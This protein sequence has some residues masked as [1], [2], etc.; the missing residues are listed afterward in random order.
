MKFTLFI[1]L[2]LLAST[3]ARAGTVIDRIIATGRLKCGAIAEPLDWN[4]NDLHASLAPLDAEMCRAVATAVLGAPDRFDLQS[5]NSEADGL[6]GLLQGK[7][8]IV[9]GVT[10]N[11]TRAARDGVRFSLP[12]FQD[13]QG[14]MVHRAAGIRTLADM[15]GHKLCYIDGTDNAAVVLSVLGALHVRPVPFPFQEEGEMDAA[16]MDLHCQVTSALMSKLAEARATFHNAGDYVFLPDTLALVPVT[17]AVDGRDARLA[18]VV[19]YTISA[20]LQAE[21]LGGTQA[22][23]ASA[24]HTEDPRLQRLLGED[25]ATAQGLGLAHDWSRRVIEAV[26]NYGEILDRTVGPGTPFN[27]P[28]GLNALWNKGGVLAP[29]PLQ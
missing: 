23:A 17:V 7:S 12:F 9:A 1:L 18:A 15:T 13:S 6:T 22:S 14:F 16:I 3:A 11:A 25:W 21:F 28:R 5:Y 20:L 24:P 26:G 4:K 29:L 2:A 8:D 10:P 19:D 27:L